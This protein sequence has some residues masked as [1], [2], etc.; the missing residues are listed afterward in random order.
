MEAK[1]SKGNSKIGG[2]PNIS[3]PPGL[4]CRK[5]ALCYKD[6]CYARKSYRMFPAV[7]R[8]WIHNFHCYNNDPEQ[9]FDSIGDQ[10]VMAEFFRWHVSGDIIDQRYFDGMCELGLLEPLTRFLVFTKKYDLDFSGT[11]DNLQTVLSIWPGMELPEDKSLPWA[12]L[13]ED[14][15]RPINDPYLMCPGNCSEGFC[16]HKCW[17]VVSKDL[18]VVFNRH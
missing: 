17:S 1:V 12:W 4:T 15:R 7:R 3:L 16:S 18:S 6:G 8:A 2:T 9:Y 5:D 14:V 11:P 10:I 13:Q